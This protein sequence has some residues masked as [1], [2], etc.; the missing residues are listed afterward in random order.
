[1]ALMQ[2]ICTILVLP[3]QRPPLVDIRVQEHLAMCERMVGA[4]Q[5]FELLVNERE[6]AAAFLKEELEELYSFWM[7]VLVAW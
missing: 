4:A 1:M 3:D 2:A 7:V 6:K 5:F